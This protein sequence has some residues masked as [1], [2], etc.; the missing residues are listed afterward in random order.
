LWSSNN[1]LTSLDVSKN[2]AL[3]AL[4]CE[5]NQLNSLDVSGNTALTALGLSGNLLT[6][7]DISNNT[8]LQ[9][10]LLN[11][12]PSLNEVC[13]WEMPFPSN[14][15]S[16]ETTNSPNVYFTTDCTGGN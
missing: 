14:D 9:V 3:Y 15:I 12:L 8:D 7:M 11:R 13:V 10:I 1:Q 4:Y 2:T 5:E 6:S 16:V